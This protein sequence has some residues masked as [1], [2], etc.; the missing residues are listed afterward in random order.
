MKE[1]YEQ[2]K[3]MADLG[4]GSGILPIVMKENAG[5]KGTITCLDS[6]ENALDCAKLNLQLYG[7]L[8]N[9]GLEMKEVDVVDLWHPISG[10]PDP[11][12]T[13]KQVNFYDK[14]SKELE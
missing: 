7:K 14:I 8:E 1:V 5:F 13:Q 12:Q 3:H 9:D 11:I 10:S 4:C 6:S 2:K